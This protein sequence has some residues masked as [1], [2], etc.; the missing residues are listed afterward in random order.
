MPA[1]ERLGSSFRDPSGFVFESEG[2]LYRQINASYEADWRNLLSS[3]LLGTLTAKGLLVPHAEAPLGNAL[4]DEAIAVIEPQRLPF[5]SYPYEWC[6][7]QLK[8]AALATLEIQ[9]LAIERGFSLKDASAYNIQFH[10]CRPVFIDT[11][12]FEAYREGTPWVAYGQFCRHFLGP[13]ALMA[14][15]DVRLGSLLKVHLDG[16][17]L[18]LASHLLPG[19]TKLRPGLLAHVHVHAK[20]QRGD[21]KHAADP[22]AKSA[23]VSKTAML[24]L[25]DSLE[26]TVKSLTWEPK[27]TEW[28]D[29]YADTITLPMPCKRSDGS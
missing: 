14:L 3:D 16:I 26:S 13:L 22:R 11:L 12:S 9:K 29:Y 8:D 24:A 23:A 25:V 4:T 19:S 15:V 21:A 18:D 27:A 7:S 2:R 10:G 5:I 1:A 6:F 20:A 28:A 17:P